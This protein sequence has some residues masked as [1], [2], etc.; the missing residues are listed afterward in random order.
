MRAAD[1][2]AKAKET[3]GWRRVKREGLSASDNLRALDK[4]LQSSLGFGLAHYA[5]KQKM[6]PGGALILDP[7]E[8]G[9]RPLLVL[10]PDE[11]KSGIQS[12]YYC[13]W[14]AQLRGFNGRDCHHRDWNDVKLAVSRSGLW[15]ASA[16]LRS[17]PCKQHSAHLNLDCAQ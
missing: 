10:V 17:W 14:G 2:A 8:A 1:P 9:D 16:V 11:Q 13:W 15:S 7:A 5:P 6:Q 4:M 12:S 3:K